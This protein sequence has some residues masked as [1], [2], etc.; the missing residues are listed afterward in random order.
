MPG[1]QAASAW[2]WLCFFILLS[3]L[4]S[5]PVGAQSAQER[6]ARGKELARAGRL[7]EALLAFD[8]AK[9]QNPKDARPYIHSGKA[10]VAAGR[11]E[12]AQNELQQVA[13]FKVEHAGDALAYAQALLGV[14]W[15]GRASQTLS[16]W[17]DSAQLESEGLWLL[18]DL[19]YRQ[20]LPE[21]AQKTLDKFAA[22]RPDD[23]RLDFRR[24]EVH[25][26]AEDHD[27]A[28]RLLRRLAQARPSQ[29]AVQ[30]LLG[31]AMWLAYGRADSKQPLL[32]AVEL[33]PANPSFL[34]TLGLVCFKLGHN[35]QAI[36]YLEQATALPEVLSEVTFDLGN[37]YRKA[38]NSAK[39]RTVLA[40][41]Q[42]LHSAE[43]AAGNRAR[44][45]EQLLNQ[46][47]RQFDQ[48]ALEE[49]RKSFLRLVELEPGHWQAHSFLAK[50]YLSL[51]Q[52]GQARPHIERML[53]INPDN[54]EGSFLMA[55]ILYLQRDPQGALPYAR[56]SKALLPGNPELRN[57]LG[58]IHLSLG[59]R[60]TALQEYKAA[61][62]LAPDNFAFRSN[63]QAISGTKAKP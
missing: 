36:R 52:V 62:N 53:E 39:A 22:R 48:G 27:Q 13:R 57:L 12:D 31:R 17:A 15:L 41:Y 63:Y 21:D 51:R 42:E 24:A 18:A 56:K 11:P 10:L 32:K 47:L 1:F 58:N 40:H 8:L 54:S 20:R 5:S 59:E 4:A 61:M 29:A 49:A 7:S 35:D 2:L 50:A 19:Y 9:Q 37:A 46:G 45:V 16:V 14:G 33:E 26:L 28:V 38:G 3:Q 25:L 60:E 34:H 44:T 23:P 55:L 30:H 43:E 6:L